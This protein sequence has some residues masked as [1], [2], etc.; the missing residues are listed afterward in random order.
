MIPKEFQI[1]GQSIKVEIANKELSSIGD[2]AYADYLSNTIKLA[3]TWN[4]EPVNEVALEQTF[5]HE[6]THMLLEK[7]GWQRRLFKDK[8]EEMEH[9]V[10]NFS[11][12]LHQALKTFK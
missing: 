8:T 6:F 10:E 7:S 9:F 5:F 12:L 11:A 3:N 1:Y 2:V 4:N